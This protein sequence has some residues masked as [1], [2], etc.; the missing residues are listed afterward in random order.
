[1]KKL[2]TVLLTLVMAV[3][4]V[5]LNNSHTK[6]ESNATITDT[7]VFDGSSFKWKSSGNPV[8]G[9]GISYTDG[10]INITDSI[11]YNSGAGGSDGAILEIT[12]N[13]AT[14][15]FN[16]DITLDCDN[17]P[18]ILFTGN[19]K[20]TVE[21]PNSKTLILMGGKNN[22]LNVTNGS[23]C[24]NNTNVNVKA[25]GGG[26]PAF[27]KNDIYVNGA[28]GKIIFDG[29]FNPS[30]AKFQGI[31][32][33]TVQGRTGTTGALSDVDTTSDGS[34]NKVFTISGN[35]AKYCEVTALTPI[36][37]SVHYG[38]QYGSSTNSFSLWKD[39]SCSTAMSKTKYS[40]YFEFDT[41]KPYIKFKSVNSTKQFVIQKPDTGE[42][43]TD[44]TIEFFGENIFNT[45]LMSTQTISTKFNLTIKSSGG[46]DNSLLITAGGYGNGGITAFGNLTFDNANVSVNIPTGA[47]D[48]V[49]I[50]L[51]DNKELT[52]NNSN[53]TLKNEG[54]SSTCLR[55]TPEKMVLNGNSSLIA[56]STDATRGAIQFHGNVTT[57]T[58]PGYKI[59]VSANVDGSI[60]Q[61]PTLQYDGT[62]Y[63]NLYAG[64]NIAKYVEIVKD[65][66]TPTPTPSPSQPKDESCEKVIGP[67]WHWNE[68]KGICEDY[69]VVGTSTR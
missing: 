13:D 53:L 24:V 7:I 63:T 48:C 42:T 29:G 50:N 35:Q 69:G 26:V 33:G 21:G 10:K 65:V 51:S 62:K 64:T 22:Y 49:G 1:M 16:N 18:A 6:A 43:E 23:F 31:V 27:V 61:A 67:T 3:C 28:N 45:S 25:G 57:V 47:N 30:S 15:S 54:S 41:T 2:L 4:L 59:L 19:G 39:S 66:P 46:N 32:Y 52:I 68:S 17:G 37:E 40:P 38:R 9:I 20:L 44:A 8:T 11:N 5:N 56:T 36:T 34:G 14:I 12:C 55:V 60:K 58:I